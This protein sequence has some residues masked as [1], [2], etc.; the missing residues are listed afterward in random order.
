MNISIILKQSCLVLCCLTIL[1][2]CKSEPQTTYDVIIKNGNLIH[3]EDGSVS[4]SNILINDNRITKIISDS[5][6][7]NIQAETIIDA[8]GKFIVPGFWDNHTHFR[9]GDSLINANKNFLK[10]FMA[11]GIT[12]VRDAGGD[13][14]SSVLEWRKAIAKNELVGPT[15]FTS[16][17]KIDGPGGTWAGSLEVDTDETITKALDSL[18]SIPSDFVKIYDS[19]ISGKDYLK[20]IQEAEKRNL[21]TSGHMPFTVELDAT[22][23]AGIDAVEHLYYIMKGCSNSEKEITIKLIDKEIGFWD[24]MP[25]LQSSFSDSTALKTFE[26]LKSNDVFVV[27]TLHIGGVLSYLDKVDHTNDAYLKYMSDGIQQTYKGR[28]DRVKNATEKQVTDRKALDTFFGKLAY[29]L[30]KNGVSLLAGS[31]S[32]AYNSYTYPGI[33]LH[34]EME[35]MV[36][37]GISPLDALKSSAY[38]GAKFLKLDAD[39]GTIS[40]GKIADIVLLNSN[41]LEDIKSTKD[42]FM[43]IS[44]GNQHTKTDL[45]N[46]LTSAIAN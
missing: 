18:Q 23:D 34:K 35:A 8:K 27:P 40:E 39:Y 7:A 26:H 29:K 24:A 44:N 38:N 2:S 21:I 43:V 12:T 19:R 9:G 5:D 32:G 30:N 13:L 17:P 4:I 6:L 25:L 33:S 3:L 11:N 28:I 42:I 10:L 37:T 14:T 20:V 36:A 15:I 31:D 45:D 22:I 16:G 41:P 46:L 1:L